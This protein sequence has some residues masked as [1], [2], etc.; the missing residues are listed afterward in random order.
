MDLG[1][2][3]FSVRAT[4]DKT[5]S[6]RCRSGCIN[7]SILNG[8]LRLDWKDEQI[9]LVKMP[10]IQ[11][12]GI[13][14]QTLIE[15]LMNGFYIIF[16]R[17]KFQLPTKLAQIEK[18]KSTVKVTKYIMRSGI[19]RLM[20]SLRSMSLTRVYLHITNLEVV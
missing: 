13:N 6:D 1:E 8:L 18:L 4:T 9:N 7:Q 11:F 10:F 17:P 3:E 12:A 20:I 14:G 19:I 5:I 15:V 2:W 16:Q